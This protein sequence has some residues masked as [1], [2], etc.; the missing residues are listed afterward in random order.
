MSV[1]SI[2]MTTVALFIAM[3]IY[4]KIGPMVGLP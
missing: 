3:V 2:A 1:K 4:N